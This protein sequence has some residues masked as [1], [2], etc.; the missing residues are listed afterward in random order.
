MNWWD[1]QTKGDTVYT[2]D[3]IQITQ[4]LGPDGKPYAIR[5]Q[6]FKLGFDLTP[7]KSKNSLDNA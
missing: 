4:V 6:N 7:Y 3:D 2:P 1:G 5:R